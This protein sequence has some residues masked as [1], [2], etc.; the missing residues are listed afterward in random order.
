MYFFFIS[1]AK[2]LLQHNVFLDSVV[3]S[4]FVERDGDI[5]SISTLGCFC[6]LESDYRRIESGGVEVSGLNR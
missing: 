5:C 3:V 2:F 6:Q 1:N 4:L